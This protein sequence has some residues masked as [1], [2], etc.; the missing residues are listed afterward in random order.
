MPMH[1]CSTSKSHPSCLPLKPKNCSVFWATLRGMDSP[2]TTFPATMGRTHPENVA[3]NGSCQ[4]PM[5]SLPTPG[6]SCICPCQTKKTCLHHLPR[7]PDW[8]HL[9]TPELQP[10]HPWPH[11]CTWPHRVEWR[12]QS[13]WQHQGAWPHQRT[14]PPLVTLVHQLTCQ[15]QATWATHLATTWVHRAT[16]LRALTITMTLV[17]ELLIGPHLCTRDQLRSFHLT[18]KPVHP[19]TQPCWCQKAV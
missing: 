13:T 5:I 6:V 1:C 10:T 8:S 2:L 4:R 7:R 9:P 16:I 11:P 17:A 15:L 3:G 18:P 14:W 19:T 12:P